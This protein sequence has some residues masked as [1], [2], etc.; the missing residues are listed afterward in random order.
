MTL[1]CT[2]ALLTPYVICRKHGKGGLK[3]MHLVNQYELK[4]RFNQVLAELSLLLVV[5]CEKDV[6]AIL[7]SDKIAVI[8]RKRKIM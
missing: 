4:S 3:I 5:R 2:D 1:A 6:I 8:K 7:F